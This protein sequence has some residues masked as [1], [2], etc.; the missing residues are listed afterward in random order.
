MP[1]VTANFLI[2]FCQITDTP[3]NHFSIVWQFKVSDLNNYIL[4][5][6]QSPQDFDGVYFPEFDLSDF[7]IL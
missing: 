5:M 1:H 4:T 7:A 2:H 3:V 6:K